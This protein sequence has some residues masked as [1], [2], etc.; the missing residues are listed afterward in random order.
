MVIIFNNFAQIK[1]FIQ[2]DIT[3]KQLSSYI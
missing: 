1:S 2:Q 3:H